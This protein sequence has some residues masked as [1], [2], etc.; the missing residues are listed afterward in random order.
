MPA[1]PQGPTS[2]RP[3]DQP[4]TQRLTLHAHDRRFRPIP[5]PRARARQQEGR[6]QGILSRARPELEAEAGIA[7]PARNK[8]SARFWCFLAGVWL[9]TAGV[10]FAAGGFARARATA[11]PAPTPQEEDSD[12]NKFEP[13]A[14][15]SP[16][17]WPAPLASSP[18]PPNRLATPALATTT[19]ASSLLDGCN[20]FTLTSA[21]TLIAAS[22]G[23][24]PDKFRVRP[25]CPSSINSLERTSSSGVPKCV[26]LRWS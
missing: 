16:P 13:P 21:P 25:S 7:K 24:Q 22:Q 6:R 26:R 10:A 4:A 11:F 12:H 15:L 18:P 9:A 3:A 20:T 17:P 5:R 23:L 1:A 14:T 19:I 8:P 2:T